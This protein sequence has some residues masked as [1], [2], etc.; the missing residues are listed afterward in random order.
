MTADFPRSSFDPKLILRSSNRSILDPSQ[1]LKYFINFS[2]ERGVRGSILTSL[3]RHT[4]SIQFAPHL[5]AF[6]YMRHGILNQ[7][8][9]VV[10]FQL[11]LF[12]RPDV[13]TTGVANGLLHLCFT[14][15][16]GKK[17]KA[18]RACF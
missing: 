8:T 11:A 16:G 5:A 6:A 14:Q 17:L 12:N 2:Q 7:G 9:G 13:G 18:R 15:F 3:L 4:V 10:K 1:F